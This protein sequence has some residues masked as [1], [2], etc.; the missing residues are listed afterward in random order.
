MTKE[1]RLAK[2]AEL[3]RT[4]WAQ[5]SHAP[6]AGCMGEHVAKTPRPEGRFE[7]DVPADDMRLKIKGMLWGLLVGD[8]LGSPIRFSGK[9]SHPWITEMVPCTIFNV[10]P[11]CWTD[12]GSMVL[13]VMDS[14]VRKGGYDLQDIG[15]TFQK[16]MS[17]GYLSSKEGELFDIGAATAFGIP[18]IIMGSLKNRSKES[19]GNGSIKRFAPSYLLARALGQRQIIYEVSDLAHSS[20]TVRKVCDEFAAVLDEHLE[21]GKTER[22][23]GRELI[24]ELV[25]NSGWCVDTLAAAL[26]A[27]NTTNSFEEGMVAAVNLGGDSD[28]I[29]AVYGQVAGAYYGFKAIPLRWVGAMKDHEILDKR[30]DD[31]IKVIQELTGAA[32]L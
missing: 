3:K 27:F 1:E 8:A 20:P 15:N 30:I 13:C 14:V 11:G 31:F 25:P 9:D 24:R 22:G 2:V 26:W 32:S 23:P 4:L 10:G 21:G 7:A 12:D 28:S 17:E 19:Q 6:A 18:S 16:W 29:G 5:G